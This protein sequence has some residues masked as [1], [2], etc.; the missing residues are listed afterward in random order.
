MNDNSE[1]IHVTTIE[2]R[3]GSTNQRLRYVLSF[4]LFF[5]LIAFA[6]ILIWA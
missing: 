5:V 2:V 3:G 6:I 1:D 4:G